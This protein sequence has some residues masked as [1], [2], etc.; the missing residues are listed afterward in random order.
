M[1]GATAISVGTA[2]FINPYATVEIVDGIQEF[3]DRNGVK[4][5]KELIGCVK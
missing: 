4:E 3:M 1:A 2:N 5:I